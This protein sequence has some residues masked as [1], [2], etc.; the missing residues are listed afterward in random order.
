[1][2]DH[3]VAAPTEEVP[4]AVAQPS[5]GRRGLL[6]TAG[7]ILSGRAV[8]Y[9]FVAVA[10]GL[11]AYAVGRQWH[12]VGSALSTIGPLPVVG[13]FVAVLIGVAGAM[14]VWRVLLAA[15]GSPLPIRASAKVVFVGQ[16]GK[17]LPGSIWPVLAQ[18][19]LG[20]VYKVPRTRS[21]TA[22]VLTMLVSLLGGLLA[23]LVTLPF[24]AGE[25][26]AY[27]WAFLVVPVLLACLHPKVLNP[28][29]NRLLRLAKRPP[30]EQP[31]TTR[32]VAVSVGWS[33]VSWLF[34]GVQIW[35]L[36][37][38]LGA[39]DGRA[40]LV[41]IGGFAFAWCVGFLI[42]FA[43]AGAGV[44]DV[45]LVALLGSVLGTGTGGATAV[46]LVSRILMTLGDLVTAGLAA[47]FGRDG[48]RP[49]AGAVTQGDPGPVDGR[50]DQSTGVLPAAE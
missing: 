18:M 28:V 21:A 13:A 29:L 36:A 37:I 35:V 2:P 23:A 27:R 34:Y 38:R 19:E 3:P 7:K 45:I 49:E 12:D 47:W 26:T 46:A 16:L 1:M 40:A 14:Q 30:L 43:P 17:Y 39:P 10:V 32:A 6:R 25:A 31:L 48:G 42:V 4:T 11:G 33:L 41:S 44:R 5:R 15:L 8:R 9:G 20:T 24:I 22:S 50:G